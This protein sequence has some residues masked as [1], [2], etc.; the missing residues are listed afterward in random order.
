MRLKL[1]EIAMAALCAVGGELIVRLCA[2]SER[3]DCHRE[4][5][6]VRRQLEAAKKFGAYWHA[7]ACD[8]RAACEQH[9][10]QPGS[11]SLSGSPLN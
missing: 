4:L 11:Q 6:L 10:E 7:K 9:L 2:T 5:A 1:A 3:L 8:Y